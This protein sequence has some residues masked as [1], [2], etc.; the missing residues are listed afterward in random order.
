MWKK[1]LTLQERGVSRRRSH[2]FGLSTEDFSPIPASTSPAGNSSTIKT[3]LKLSSRV[4][5][6][7][8]KRK[9]FKNVAVINRIIWFDL[10]KKSFSYVK[11]VYLAPVVKSSKSRIFNL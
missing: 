3:F 8:V 11:K 5:L 4:Q 7:V 9:L 1:Q 6:N 2:V 10:G